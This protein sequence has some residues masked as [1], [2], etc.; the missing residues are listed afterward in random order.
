MKKIFSAFLAAIMMLSM[1][2]TLVLAVTTPSIEIDSVYGKPGELVDVNVKIKNNPGIIAATLTFSFDSNLTLVK[3]ENGNAF[4]ALSYTAPNQLAS[5]GQITS[6]CRFLWKADTISAEDVKDGT[7]ITLTFK[8]SGSAE[9]GKSYGIA[10]STE[11]GDVLDDSLNEYILSANTDV[12]TIDY[13][14]GDVNSDGKIN[15]LDVVLL[16][17]YIVDGCKFDADGYAVTIDEKAGNVNNDTRIN[18]LDVVLL[19]RYIVDGCKYDPDGYAVKLLA[20]SKK[21]AHVMTAMAYND[22]TC[23]EDGNIAYWYCS[24]CEKYFSDANGTNE[25]AQADT[26]INAI[27]HTPVVDPAVAPTY[28][29]PGKTEGSHCS[30]CEKVLVEQIIIPTLEKTEYSITYKPAYNDEYLQKIDFASQLP[31]ESMKYTSEDGIYELPQLEVAGYNFVGWFNGTSSQ[32]TQVTELPEGTKGNKTL[33][34]KWELVP[35]TIQFDSPDVPVD[36]ITYTVNTGKTLTSPSWFGYTFVGWSLNGKIISSIKS[37]T[38]GNVILHA[39]WT[40]NRNQ[41]RAVTN[42]DDP[43][44]IEDMDNARF[45]FVYEIG[46]INNVPLEQIKYYGNTDGITINEEFEYTRSVQESTANTVANVVSNATTKTSSWTLSEDWNKTSSATNEHEE[47]IGKTQEKTDSLGQVIGSKYYVSNSSGGATSTSTSSGGSSST[48]S[49]VT[50][51]SSTGING[52][53]T[54]GSETD[55]SISA[56]VNVTVGSEAG[57]EVDAKVAKVNGKV[58]QET[59]VGVSGSYAKK[60]NESSTIAASRAND[61]S[62]E[63]DSSS[64]SYYDTSSSS[65]STWNSETGYESSKETSTNTSVSNAISQLVND[66]YSYSSAESFGASNS[67]TSSTGSSSELTNEYSSTVEYSV[68]QSETRK[69][70]ITYQSS[71]E[72]YYRLVTAG[73]VHVFAVVGYDI[74]TNSYFTYTY[75]VLDKERHTYLDYSKDNANFN[76]CENAILPFEVPYSVHEYI[77]GVIGKSS[78]ITVDYNTGYVTKYTGV[79]GNVTIP[80]YV[81]RANGDGTYSAVRVRGINSNVFQGNK[82]ITGINLSKYVSEIPDNAFAGCTN[83]KE[84]YALGVSKIGNEAFAGCTS[85]KRYSVD[86]YITSLGSNVFED[87]QEVSVVAANSSVADNAIN[88]GAKKLSVNVAN[89]SD[90]FNNRKVIIDTTT[91][92]FALIGNGSPINNLSIESS[93]KETV[94][95]NVVFENNTDTPLK[96]N[97][98]KITLNRVTVNDAPGFAMILSYDG[99]QVRLFD[100]VYLSSADSNAVIS[101]NISLIQDSDEVAGTLKLNGNLLVCGNTVTGKELALFDDGKIIYISAEE[102]EMYLTSSKVTFDA[103]GGKVSESGKTVYYGQSYGALPVPTRDNYTFTG[104]YTAVS[105][106]TKVLPTDTVT[107]LSN[108]TLYAQ[109]TPN[110][111]TLTYNANGGSVS[112][113]SKVITFGNSYGTLPTPTRDYYTFAGWYT[114]ASGGTKVSASTTPSSD[115]DVTIYAHWTQNSVS[116]W[117]KAA[118]V[119]SGAQIVNRKYTYTLTSYTTSSSSTLSGWTKYNTT[120]AWGSYGAWSAWQDS[121]VSASDSRQV[122]TQQVVASYDYQTYYNYYYY[123]KAETGYETSYYPNNTYGKNYYPVKRTSEL[124]KVGTVS[125]NGYTLTKYKMW[126]TNNT[127]FRYVYA[128]Y[129]GVTPNTY[130]T[131]EVVKTNY[132][133]QYRYRDRSLVYTYYFKKEEAKESATY[134]TGN[135]I[136]NIVEM[137]QYRAK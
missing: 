137:V 101:K 57:A 114:A 67:T 109:W 125:Y 131:Q 13:T 94:I 66:K 52:S 90:N 128:C 27:G 95:N 23:E 60:D 105:G 92:Y 54:Q 25:I 68:E 124:E 81:S 120:S 35:Y 5:G 41:A 78:T 117:V 7:I 2:P 77:M 72:G 24:E 14:P 116:S 31:A 115:D 11:S 15:T 76:D 87:V 129:A 33:Y 51:G 84:I 62:V 30:V 20:V 134:P 65:S 83:L 132:K 103:N 17:R 88:C 32:A 80:Q 28:T 36:S 110:E 113:A 3:A 136:S 42:L 86:E 59:D 37:G 34:A 118:D 102:Y 126:H 43:L 69:E 98:G 9:I 85:L 48:S 104:W 64:S 122:E 44:I 123:S 58:Y 61:H 70:T 16:S 82:D 135:N 50:D 6:S 91:D 39:N 111:F 75:N 130:K 119:P 19:S 100:T 4:S 46:T 38:I 22:A 8:I 55:A 71:V 108:Q 106:G 40:S 96:I 74:A 99:A 10:V 73:T 1:L 133:T 53:Y 18:T 127:K 21:C 12:V 49:K 107:S 97:S 89:I 93:A 79:G 26:V 56:S 47:E 112:P 29:A 121:A 45:V 63:N